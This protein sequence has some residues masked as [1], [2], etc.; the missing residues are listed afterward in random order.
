MRAR[1]HLLS[2]ACVLGHVTLGRPLKTLSTRVAGGGWAR[3]ACSTAQPLPRHGD[4]DPATVASALRPPTPPR[5][6]PGPFEPGPG[7]PVPVR[8]QFQ[9]STS[10]HGDPLNVVRVVPAR[11]GTVQHDSPAG[12]DGPPAARPGAPAV[13]AHSGVKFTAVAPAG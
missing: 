10:R 9:P 8:K 1:P 3:S 7:G 5:P 2:C 13:T 11:G 6:F 4:G 12:G